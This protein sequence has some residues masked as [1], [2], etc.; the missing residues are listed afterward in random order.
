MNKIPSPFRA[1]SAT[2]IYRTGLIGGAV[3]AITT[4]FLAVRNDVEHF[5][6]DPG[7]L[8]GY[9]FAI[10]F[11]IAI[12][13]FFAAVLAEKISD[14]IHRVRHTSKE[15]R[16]KQ[17]GKPERLFILT[18]VF[19]WT[20]ALVGGTVTFFAGD[21]AMWHNPQRA[22]SDDPIYFTLIIF[23]WFVAC[24]GPIF[25]L[26]AAVETIYRQVRKRRGR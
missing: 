10:F 14:G 11:L 22:I 9:A 7:Y 20:G 15:E 16:R 17:E 5:A 26:A 1:Q 8:I 4:G 12:P 13:C 2:T 25:L 19:A 18:R 23:S 3:T 6:E 24:G 21:A